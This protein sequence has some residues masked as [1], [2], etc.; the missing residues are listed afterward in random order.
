MEE[1]ALKGNWKL[2]LKIMRLF[3]DDL[4][5]NVLKKT[6]ISLITMLK[7]KY[8]EQRENSA[9]SAFSFIFGFFGHKSSE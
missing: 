8:I 4:K 2:R 5:N 7:L 1:L 3:F 9:F 6:Q